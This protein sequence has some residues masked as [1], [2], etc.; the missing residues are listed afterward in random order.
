[1]LD[2]AHGIHEHHDMLV[3]MSMSRMRWTTRWHTG[4]TVDGR[5][6][7]TSAEA[8][9]HFCWVADRMNRQ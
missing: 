9:P 4:Y 5:V 8:L 7:H 1:V 2:D 3:M 6:Q